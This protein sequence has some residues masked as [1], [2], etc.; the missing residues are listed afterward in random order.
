MELIIAGQGFAVVKIEEGTL[1]RLHLTLDRAPQI[2]ARKEPIMLLV[3]GLDRE[4]VKL[5]EVAEGE[6]LLVRKIY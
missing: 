5:I 3:D 6:C 4:P 2:K 1:Q